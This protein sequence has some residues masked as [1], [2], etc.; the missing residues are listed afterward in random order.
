VGHAERN[1][2][3]SDGV[4]NNAGIAFAVKNELDFVCYILS[5]TCR[6]VCKSSLE[7]IVTNA[8]IVKINDGFVELISRIIRK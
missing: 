5:A 7:L 8:G 1:F 2:T 4:Y 6:I 3:F